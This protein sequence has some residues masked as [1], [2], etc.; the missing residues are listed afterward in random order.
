MKTLRLMV[1]IC[2]LLTGCSGL[3]QAPIS[4]F[5]LQTPRPFGYLI[6]DEIKHRVIL[7]TRQDLSLNFNSVPAQGEVNRWLH[8]NKV[9]VSRQNEGRETVI[10][11]SYQVF[12]APAEVKMLTIPGYILQFNQAGKIVEQQIPE[13]HF[14]LSP[15]KELAVRK[16][17]DGYQYM[18]PDAPPRYLATQS[19]WMGVYISLVCGCSTAVY[20]AYLYGYLPI[21]SR[22]RIF[23][24]AC[25]QLANLSEREMGRSL[26]VVHH[27][28]NT[29]NGQPLFPHQ[30][31]EFYQRH[32]EYLSI[33]PKID[34]FF[35]LS[36]QV[37]FAGWQKFDAGEWLELKDLCRLCREIERGSR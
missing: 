13:W 5:E 19:L 28:L 8:L 4:H 16:D 12:Y 2:S 25:R 30:L 21:L 9:T 20:L 15:L 3:L 34:W 32:P 35:N 36:N 33:K 26:A 23:K 22:Q 7:E 6:G 29:L 1:M 11:L 37:L 10:D 17:N 18:R 27:A 31:K 24:R 14:T